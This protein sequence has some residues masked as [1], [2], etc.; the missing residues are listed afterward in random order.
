M[1]QDSILGAILFSLYSTPLSKIIQ[2]YPSIHFPFYAD[3]MQLYVHLTH[4]YVTDAFDRLKNCLGD[5]KKLLSANKLELDP[6]KTGLMLLVSRI[7][8]ANLK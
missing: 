7:V 5:V 1:P 8:H 4:K 3:D 2:N 6:D